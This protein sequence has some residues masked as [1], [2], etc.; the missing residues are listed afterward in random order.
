MSLMYNDAIVPF[1]T[2]K[3]K[4]YEFSVWTTLSSLCGMRQE[5]L[6]SIEE[7]AKM[8]NLSVNRTRRIIES[9]NTKGVIV[10]KPSIRK[11][12]IY[13]TVVYV[14]PNPDASEL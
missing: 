7:S 3:L 5:H 2:F 4:S 14:D 6:V 12:S 9:L 13:C 11:D 1:W 10:T 8:I